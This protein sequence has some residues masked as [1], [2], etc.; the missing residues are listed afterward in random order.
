MN[1]V[2]SFSLLI[3]IIV[4]GKAQ[5]QQP[6]ED[7][8]IKDVLGKIVC[9]PPGGGIYKEVLGQIVSGRW[10]CILDVLDQI[11]TCLASYHS[12]IKI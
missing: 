5:A 2:P 11:G 8:C 6:G 10:Q 12:T 4:A 3:A 1:R 7:G 9:L